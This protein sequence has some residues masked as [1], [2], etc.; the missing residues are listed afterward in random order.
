MPK[1]IIEVEGLSK[2]YK[3]GAMG[4]GTISHDINR[5]WNKLRKI[6]DPFM[7]SAEKNDR[8]A[9]GSSGYIWSLKDINFELKEGEIMGIIGSNGAGK[10]TLLKLLSKITKPTSG[11][12]RLD[13][14]VASLLEVGTG[15][16]P[17]L[18]GKEN[19]F[20]KLSG[21]ELTSS[22]L[23]NKLYPLR[24]P[25]LMYYTKDKKDSLKDL[26]QY[27]KSEDSKKVIRKFCIEAF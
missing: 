27:F 19:V 9:T 25:V 17:E 4:S 13:G 7:L 2:L 18:T 11:T 24:F 3:L 6:E 8:N 5:W 26:F 12:I 16:H 22:N 1:N 23:K 10:S 15:F 14:K 21:I 20:L